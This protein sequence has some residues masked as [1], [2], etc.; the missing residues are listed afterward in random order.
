MRLLPKIWDATSATEFSTQ[1]MDFKMRGL[2]WGSAWMAASPFEIHPASQDWD[3]LAMH[4]DHTNVG[5]LPDRTLTQE[6]CISTS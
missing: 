4:F 1:E 2:A 6:N 5:L 3:L